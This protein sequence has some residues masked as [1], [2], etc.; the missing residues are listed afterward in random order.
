MYLKYYIILLPPP[1]RDVLDLFFINKSPVRGV[2][3]FM[4]NVDP[5]YIYIFLYYLF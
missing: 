4:R 1:S 2:V 3:N 5:Q